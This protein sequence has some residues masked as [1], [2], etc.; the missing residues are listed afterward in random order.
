MNELLQ[1][2][3]EKMKEIDVVKSDIQFSIELLQRS[4][5]LYSWCK[6]S[7]HAPALDVLIG[8]YNRLEDLC[9]KFKLEDKDY[10]AN[11]VDDLTDRLW[12][13]IR[14]E[15]LSKTFFKRKKPVL[16]PSTYKTF[17]PKA[18]AVSSLMDCH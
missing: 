16:M 1:E 4:P 15:S 3:C 5:R 6:S 12:H 2:I 14:E 8:L 17:I 18:P 13:K 9:E 10:D 7:K 11:I